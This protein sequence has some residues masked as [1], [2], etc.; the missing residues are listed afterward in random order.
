MRALV[1]VAAALVL[2]TSLARAEYIRKS[3]EN[4]NTEAA[5]MDKAA[6]DAAT[7]AKKQQELEDAYK[8]AMQK[9]KPPATPHDPW[10]SVR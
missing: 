10:A 4:A 1:A 9:N 7:A 8:A 2:T 3:G 5:E 6:R